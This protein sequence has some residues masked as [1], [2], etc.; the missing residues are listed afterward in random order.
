LVDLLGFINVL[1]NYIAVARETLNLESRAILSLGLAQRG[2][3]I[4]F[5]S[6]KN[7]YDFHIIRL[8]AIT[9][10]EHLIVFLNLTVLVEV[11]I[12]ENPILGIYETMCGRVPDLG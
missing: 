1:E 3:L 7:L 5:R 4:I 6:R 11:H 12:F 9:S 2:F 8:D 10:D